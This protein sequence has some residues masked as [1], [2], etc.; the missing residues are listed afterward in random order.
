MTDVN[1]SRLV[2][3]FEGKE[4]TLELGKNLRD[5]Q[6]GPTSKLTGTD[7]RTLENDDGDLAEAANPSPPALA[8]DSGTHDS[9]T[10][11]PPTDPTSSDE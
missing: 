9:D 6:A 10:G 11:D 5:M 1:P 3:D 7:A 4:F 2:L 8:A